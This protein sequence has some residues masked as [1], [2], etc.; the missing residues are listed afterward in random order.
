MHQKEKGVNMK[1]KGFILHSRKEFVEDNFG[2]DGWKKVLNALTQDDQKILGDF[3][4]TTNWYD[5]SVGNRLDKAI[6]AVLGDG[7]STVFENIGAKSAQR[8]L[9]GIHSSFLSKGDPQAFMEKTPIIYKFYYDV[10]RREYEKTGENSGVMT[11][12]E[13]ETFSGPDCLTVVGWYKQALIMCGATSVEVNETR[14]RAAG[15]LCCEYRVS[16]EI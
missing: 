8:N 4:L 12:W 3:I 2:K 9:T 10:G 7:Y 14:C 1:I 13:A 11:T 15:D 6:V 16:W 5:F